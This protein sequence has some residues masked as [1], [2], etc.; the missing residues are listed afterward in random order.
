MLPFGQ[1]DENIILAFN[2]VVLSPQT[3]LENV[4]FSASEC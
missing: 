2:Y 4:R 1:D 3:W